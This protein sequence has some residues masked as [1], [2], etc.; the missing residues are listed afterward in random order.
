MMADDLAIAEVSDSGSADWRGFMSLYREAFQAWEREPE[1]VLA[2]RVRAGR[3]LLCL[4][5]DHTGSAVGFYIL[6]VNRDVD[7]VM[8]TYVG[9]AQSARGR[10]LG[11]ALVRDAVRRF[12]DEIGAE[13]MLIEA[14]DRQAQFYGRLGFKRLDLDYHAPRFEEEGAAP[15]HLL[16]MAANDQAE[17]IDGS[18]LAEMVRHNFVHG[19][20]VAEDDPRVRRQIAEIGPRVRCERWPAGGEA[21]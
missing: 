3:Y 8:F 6:E 16:S 10:G 11:T 2:A 21:C 9:V 7:Y 17:F 15:M 19:Y 4:G 14:G 13:W 20:R 5:R 18:R 12:R 1:D